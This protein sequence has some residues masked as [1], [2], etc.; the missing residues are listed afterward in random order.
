M[1]FRIGFEGVNRVGKGTQIGRLLTLINEKYG[2]AISIRG[3]GSRQASGIEGDPS[4]DWWKNINR[5]IR[6]CGTFEDWDLASCRLIRE[7]QVWERRVLPRLVYQ[8]K[9]PHGFLLID[10]TILSHIVLHLEAGKSNLETLYVADQL[11]CRRRITYREACPDLIIHLTAP[12]EVLLNRLD[13]GDPKYHFRR[14]LI[15]RPYDWYEE[16]ISRLPPD[17]QSS[18]VSIE[19]IETPER[20]FCRVLGAINA[21]FKLKLSA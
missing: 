21:Q 3:S 16:A 17:L 8:T 2:R 15:E 10:R 6:E 12:R 5:K 7:Q 13:P 14:R 9:S 4:S 19:S 18:I 1:I 11:L 20:V